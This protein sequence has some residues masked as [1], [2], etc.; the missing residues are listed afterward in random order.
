[1]Q[2][3]QVPELSDFE[4]PGTGPSG[5]LANRRSHVYRDSSCK[6]Y[7]A[8]AERKNVMTFATADEAE[9]AG[10]HKASDCPRNTAKE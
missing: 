2:R 9:Q 4:Y 7:G 5:V 8:M 6:G 1:M 3:K 10:Y